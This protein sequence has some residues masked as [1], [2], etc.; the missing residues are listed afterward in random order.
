MTVT[1]LI[2]AVAFQITI[3]DDIPAVGYTTACDLIFYLSYTTIMV[4]MIQTIY[5]YNL[6]GIGKQSRADKLEK[7][8]V[9]LLPI[10]YIT[11]LLMIILYCTA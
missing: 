5:T 6:V 7:I 3:S 4:A 9:W 11:F 1:S 8:G 10:F 2:A